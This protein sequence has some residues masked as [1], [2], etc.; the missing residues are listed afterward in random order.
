MDS[1]AILTRAIRK[2][3]IDMIEKIVKI[4]NLSKEE[5]DKLLKEFIKPNYYNPTIVPY[6][7]QE[8]I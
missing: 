6:K 7:K 2:T 8:S 5:H 1:V 4:K 3:N